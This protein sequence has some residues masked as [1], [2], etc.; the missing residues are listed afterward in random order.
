M[1]QTST[2]TGFVARSQNEIWKTVKDLKL[3]ADPNGASLIHGDIAWTVD[4]AAPANSFIRSGFAFRKAW[5]FRLSRPH[6]TNY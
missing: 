2:L 1:V 4:P 6:R 3:A 5:H